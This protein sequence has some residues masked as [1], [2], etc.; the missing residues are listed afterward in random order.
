MKTLAIL[1]LGILLLTATVSAGGYADPKVYD[2]WRPATIAAA[3]AANVIGHGNRECIHLT[4][5]YEI[6]RNT[7]VHQTVQSPAPTTVPTFNPDTYVP[8]VSTPTFDPTKYIVPTNTP[9]FNPNEFVIPKGTPY[10]NPGN[11][12]WGVT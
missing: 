9:T 1:I 11:F 2:E 3:D 6:G 7:I 10:F 12:T 4:G 8:A 5:L